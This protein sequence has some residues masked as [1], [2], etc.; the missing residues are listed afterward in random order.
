METTVPFITSSEVQAQ[1]EAPTGYPDAI[2]YNKYHHH[3]I[4][5]NA[6][7][8]PATLSLELLLCVSRLNH[9]S[10]KISYCTALHASAQKAHHLRDAV[11]SLHGPHPRAQTRR[12][13]RRVRHRGGLEVR[14]L[15][16]RH[17]LLNDCRRDV[18][19][20]VV[21]KPLQ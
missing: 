4:F 21:A 20:V 19:L 12:R 8:E 17:D 16:K 3:E 9:Y 7:I 5:R 15:D 1:E 11:V 18:V 2:E 14:I 6:T 10:T 13:L